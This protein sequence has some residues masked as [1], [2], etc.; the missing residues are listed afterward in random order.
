MFF[1]TMLDTFLLYKS[2]T[3]FHFL[4]TP[5]SRLLFLS[6]LVAEPTKGLAL[7]PFGL[8]F[9]L[10]KGKLAEP[11]KGLA[12]L[13]LQSQPFG[14]GSAS[15]SLLRSSSRNTKN[16]GKVKTKTKGKGFALPH[17][18]RGRGI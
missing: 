4:A 15:F 2:A 18:L 1:I 10:L 16:K 3:E 13:L 6:P 7:L 17:P 11:T 12:L 9:S 8:W 14:Y 5:F